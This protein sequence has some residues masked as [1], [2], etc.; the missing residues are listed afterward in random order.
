VA[1]VRNRGPAIPPEDLAYV[2]DRFYRGL[3]GRATSGSGL[4]LSIAK[5]IVEK[6]GGSIRLASSPHGFTELEI[7]LRQAPAYPSEPVYPSEIV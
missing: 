7:R 5:W 1:R 4:G 6:H 3:H 2:F